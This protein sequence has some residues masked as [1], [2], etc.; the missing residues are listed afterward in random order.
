MIALEF[1][2][3]YRQPWVLRII[4]SAQWFLFPHC[5]IRLRLH[6]IDAWALG[7]LGPKA[8]IRK[9]AMHAQIGTQMVGFHAPAAPPAL[10][11]PTF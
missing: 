1:G 8:D 7:N 10:C 3:S 2:L 4:C 5:C 9:T 11:V 6:P